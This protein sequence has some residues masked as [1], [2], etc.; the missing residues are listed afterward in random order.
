MDEFIATLKG[1]DF[2]IPLSQVNER[3][4]A[5]LFDFGGVGVT[6]IVEY[7]NVV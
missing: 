2:F 1:N 5:T 7:W 4:N 3:G 6:C